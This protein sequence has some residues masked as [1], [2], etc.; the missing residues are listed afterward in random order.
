MN[1]LQ[2]I[3]RSLGYGSA[4]IAAAAVSYTTYAAVT[5]ARYGRVHPERFPRDD[6]LDRFLPC[7]EVDECHRIRVGAP[8]AATFAVAV[9]NLHL[10][11]GKLAR[12]AL[13][14]ASGSGI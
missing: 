9:A 13:A 3:R 5:W 7:P 14:G 10:L 6:L 4:A 11:R 12:Q 8:A 2:T 1:G